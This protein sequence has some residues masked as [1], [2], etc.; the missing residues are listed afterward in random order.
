MVGARLASAQILTAINHRFFD[1][2]PGLNDLPQGPSGL[3]P[4]ILR[5]GSLIEAG[6]S[7]PQIDVSSLQNIQA[8]QA[9]KDAIIRKVKSLPEGHIFI[10][11]VTNFDE[12]C[13]VSN[14]VS[15]LRR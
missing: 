12:G 10:P 13:A 4:I 3:R 6:A 1:N 7:A 8:P 5:G 11:M 15:D 14:I 9:V 2:S